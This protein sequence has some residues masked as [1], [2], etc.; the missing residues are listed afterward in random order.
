MK[1]VIKSIPSGFHQRKKRVNAFRFLKFAAVL[2]FF[3]FVYM[4]IYQHLM[5]I[6]RAAEI[7]WI[8]C[9]YWV[10]PQCL[11]WDM[12]ISLFRER[13]SPF[14]YGRH[15]YR[16]VL[17]LYCFTLCVHG[18]SLQTIRRVPNGAR[19][20]RKFEGS[21]QK[22]LILTHYDTI[23]HD[24]MDKLTQFGYPFVLVVEQLKEALRLHDMQIPVMLGKLDDAKTFEDAGIRNSAMVVASD[25][26]IRNVNIAFRARE[27]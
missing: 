9:F 2:I 24:L 16:S 20:P 12:V 11:L 1:E 22:H 27:S 10:L 15:V 13:R 19:I 8:E 17:P 18:I 14:F 25:D 26:D 4:N 5:S 6:E 21:E 3:V 7:G 23:S